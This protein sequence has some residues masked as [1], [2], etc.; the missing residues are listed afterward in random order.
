MTVRRGIGASSLARPDFPQPQGWSERNSA[1]RPGIHFRTYAGLEYVE[2]EGHTGSGDA[3]VRISRRGFEQD[4]DRASGP[5]PEKAKASRPAA[6]RVKLL[7]RP[8]PEGRRS[9]RSNFD[10]ESLASGPPIAAAGGASH[11]LNA[12]SPVRAGASYSSPRKTRQ[13]R[14]LYP[15]RVS[16]RQSRGPFWKDVMILR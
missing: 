3:S 6:T 4:A 7:A 8:L 15:V 13:I 2:V 11:L 12:A 16:E 9:L 1:S 10:R 14:P 5:E